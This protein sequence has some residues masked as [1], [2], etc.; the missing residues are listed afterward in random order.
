MLATFARQCCTLLNVC[1]RKNNFFYCL[2]MRTSKCVA[3]SVN[4]Q[5]GHYATNCALGMGLYDVYD[6]SNTTNFLLNVKD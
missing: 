2:F 1:T 6:T 3:C 5:F 4:E